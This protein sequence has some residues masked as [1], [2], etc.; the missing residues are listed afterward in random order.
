MQLYENQVRRNKWNI[1]KT[2]AITECVKWM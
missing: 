2:R 1:H